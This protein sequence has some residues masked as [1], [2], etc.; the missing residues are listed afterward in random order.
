LGLCVLGLGAASCATSAQGR[1]FD[2]ETT[3]GTGGDLALTG[4]GGLGSGVGG[5]TGLGVAGAGSDPDAGRPTRLDSE[6]GTVCINIGSYGKPGTTGFMPGVDNTKAFE[7]WLNDK[8]SATAS[9]VTT[10]QKLTADFLAGFDVLILQDLEDANPKTGSGPYWQFAADEVDAVAK[11]VNDG[12]G[13]IA[14]TGYSGTANEVD[15]TNALLKF[16]NISYNKDDVLSMCPDMTTYGPNC[17][18]VGG[19]VPMKG[20]T[21]GDPIAANIKE[22]GAYYG[23]T[24]TAG[25]DAAVVASVG[26][27]KYAVSKTV[28]KGKVFVFGD[29]WVTY[30]SQWGAPLMQ[31]SMMNDP[32]YMAGAMQHYQVPQFWYNAIKWVAPPNTCF[33]IE[34]PAIIK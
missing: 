13:L 29:E 30:T 8:S 11:W 4:T 26:T 28:G 31:N 23:R 20:W 22:V 27:S 9:M 34:D 5:T 32:C 7:N 33:T 21:A 14:L 12:G 2:P 25:A 16:A 3:G 19:S 10:H 6:G 24:I 1:G 17:W 18:C 15:P